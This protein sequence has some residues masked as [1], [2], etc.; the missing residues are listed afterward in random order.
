MPAD[1]ATA[2][3]E[4]VELTLEGREAIVKQVRELM[5][6][7]NRMDGDSLPVSKFV[8]VADGQW[9]LGASAYEKRGVASWFRTGTSQ[10]HPVQTSAPSCARTPRSARSS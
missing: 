9:E 4:K 6:P 7:I 5:E 8:D 3:D 10:V 2:E 1:W